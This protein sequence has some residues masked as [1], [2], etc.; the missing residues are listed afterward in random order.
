MSEQSQSPEINRD[1]NSSN[2]KNEG[3]K[4]VV[5]QPPKET[6]TKNAIT[7]VDAGIMPANTKKEIKDISTAL[8]I[9]NNE[10]PSIEELTTEQAAKRS[11][12]NVTL[13]IPNF[14]CTIQAIEGIIVS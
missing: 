13:P 12:A 6:Q 1:V 3:I 5:L 7:N 8:K 14:S 11:K 2:S 10:I 9:N 4:P